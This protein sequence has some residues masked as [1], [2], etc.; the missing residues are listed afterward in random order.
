MGKASALTTVLSPSL[1]LPTSRARS[2]GLTCHQSELSFIP[3]NVRLYQ[4][5]ASESSSGTLW[6]SPAQGM[7]TAR[8]LVPWIPGPWAQSPG[9]WHSFLCLTFPL[10]YLVLITLFGRVLRITVCHWRP[11]R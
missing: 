1:L 8:T 4:Q 5:P 3:Q 9:S 11:E 2:F 7:F 6:S 10:L